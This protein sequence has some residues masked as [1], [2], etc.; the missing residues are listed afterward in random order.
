MLTLQTNLFSDNPFEFVFPGSVF[1][2]VAILALVVA[3]VGSYIPANKF[4]HKDIAIA[5]RGL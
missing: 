1:A 2:L 4:R 3:V 5:L